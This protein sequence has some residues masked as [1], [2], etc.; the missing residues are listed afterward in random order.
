MSGALGGST[1]IKLYYQLLLSPQQLAALG[2]P[3]ES[4][5]QQEP[6]TAAATV[7][8]GAV[9]QAVQC[10]AGQFQPSGIA[11]EAPAGA[12]CALPVV[13]PGRLPG[14][15]AQGE[16]EWDEL[17]VAAA[18]FA[19]EKGLELPPGMVPPF[20]SPYPQYAQSWPPYGHHMMAPHGAHNGQG[21]GSYGMVPG[22]AVATEHA[23]MQPTGM[24]MQP[25]AASQLPGTSHQ[26]QVA[27][28][29]T[30]AAAVPDAGALT[31]PSAGAVLGGA[32]EGEGEGDGASDDILA[33]AAAVAEQLLREEAEEEAGA[34][35]AA[36]PLEAAPQGLVALEQVMGQPETDGA[37]VVMVTEQM[38]WGQVA[39]G[40]DVLQAAVAAVTS[41]PGCARG[42]P[43]AGPGQEH[44][45]QQQQE[46]GSSSTAHAHAE[47]AHAAATGQPWTTSAG[48]GQAVLERPQHSGVGELQHRMSEVGSGRGPP[49]TSTLPLPSCSSRPVP[50]PLGGSALPA[51]PSMMPQQL[52]GAHM[53]GTQPGFQASV[54]PGAGPGPLLAPLPAAGSLVPAASHPDAT[55]AH[56]APGCSRLA[57]ELDR[58]VLTDPTSGQQPMA[59]SAQA[60][61]PTVERRVGALG[62]LLEGLQ[63]RQL[64]AQLQQAAEPTPVRP[65]LP[66]NLL[67]PPPPPPVHVHARMAAA[68]AQLQ[69]AAAAPQ[70]HAT[71]SMEGVEHAAGMQASHAPHVTVNVPT[72]SQAV[73]MEGLEQQAG[74]SGQQQA[75]QDVLEP[76][77]RSGPGRPEGQPPGASGA[78]DAQDMQQLELQQPAEQQQGPPELQQ[79][80]GLHKPA[81]H[82]GL[83]A[84][85]QHDVADVQMWEAE[86]SGVQDLNGSGGQ[87]VNGP[88]PSAAIAARNQGL[89][90]A[91]DVPAGAAAGPSTAPA[92]QQGQGHEQSHGLSQAQ[93]AGPSVPPA[94][95]LPPPP[96]Q[97]QPR[98]ARTSR[99]SSL[100]GPSAALLAFPRSPPAPFMFS[101]AAAA[102]AA[103]ADAV[104][105]DTPNTPTPGKIVRARPVRRVGA[106]PI[107]PAKR[108]LSPS[109]KTSVV[110]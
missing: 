84:S 105:P 20:P 5:M 107:T 35:E 95:A 10:Q 40:G 21:G 3:Q 80:H 82:V 72:A 25:P 81:G 53:G 49:S 70:Q 75:Q 104:S 11:S 47:S 9:P 64:S 4:D 108:S 79:Q 66:T 50:A 58:V 17:D 88:G 63:P 85:G 54:G 67:M 34:G 96:P 57:S 30:S 14:E 2:V 61:G 91:G 60:A 69:A 37:P 102:A 87:D 56:A 103:H 26:P 86:G 6:A 12:A 48:D 74:P 22:A 106:S 24:Y 38:V 97:V 99:Q 65:Q 94:G 101:R 43:L 46:P 15:A 68:A 51:D 73:A 62:P 33:I 100:Q 42:G 39:T 71:A 110:R 109:G 23:S 29:T 92:R 1:A 78:R 31:G 32:G 18:M 52:H 41:G 28:G 98:A 77:E 45:N 44:T 93:G 90:H 76:Q 16:Y 13:A 89:L 59:M 27:A 83:N 55:P 7:S 8:A 19:Q 36:D